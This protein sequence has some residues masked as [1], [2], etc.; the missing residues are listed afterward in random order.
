VS[1]FRH[2]IGTTLPGYIS[3]YYASLNPN[4]FAAMPSLHAAYPFLGFLALRRVAPRA[5]WGVFAWCVVVWLS[6]VYV[7]DHYVIDVAAGVLTATV[8]WLVMTRVVAPRVASLRDPVPVKAA[9]TLPS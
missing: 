1:G 5:A 9:G 4:H 7:G 8:A 2:A 6:I 3:P